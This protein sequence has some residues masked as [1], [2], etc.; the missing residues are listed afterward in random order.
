MATRDVAVF[1]GQR[2]P[3]PAKVLFAQEEEQVQ[4]GTTGDMGVK[5]PMAELAPS[6]PGDCCGWV[7]GDG[8]TEM[9]R[10]RWW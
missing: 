2:W 5:C 8:A 7:L 6:A 9:G 3:L 4:P 1:A 10:S